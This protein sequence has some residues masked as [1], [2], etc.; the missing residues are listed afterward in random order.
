MFFGASA[1]GRSHKPSQIL[2]HFAAFSMRETEQRL[3]SNGL[4]TELGTVAGI[5]R[6]LGAVYDRNNSDVILVGYRHPDGEPLDLN[7]LVAALRALLVGHQWP[8]VSI[9]R[10]PETPISGK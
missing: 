3:R 2:G 10:T 6:L 4:T 9:D 7:D 8:L 5:K 1:C